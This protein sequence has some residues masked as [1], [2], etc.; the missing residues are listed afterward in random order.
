MSWW[1]TLA[2]RFVLTHFWRGHN[3]LSRLLLLPFLFLHLLLDIQLIL[4]DLLH[5]LSFARVVLWFKVESFLN[6]V[7]GARDSNLLVR[8]IHWLGLSVGR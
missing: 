3:L 7:C 5:E 2:H 1:F 6:F 4:K 8:Q